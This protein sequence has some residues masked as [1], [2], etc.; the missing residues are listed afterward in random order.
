ML[1][2][3]LLGGTRPLFI[4]IGANIGTSTIAALALPMFD[5]AVCCEPETENFRMLGANLALNDLDDVKRFQV[6]VSARPAR[7]QLVVV[8]GPPG[9]T[10]VYTDPASVRQKRARLDA[11]LADNPGG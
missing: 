11:Y 1:I 6:A 10:T 9:K 5:S 3:E 2:D 7:A 4:D 8:G